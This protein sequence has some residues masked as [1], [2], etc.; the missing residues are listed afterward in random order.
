M[1][2][3]RS[4]AWFW[5]GALALFAQLASGKIVQAIDTFLPSLGKLN[6]GAGQWLATTLHVPIPKEAP[7]W[8]FF[9]LAFAVLWFFIYHLTY[10]NERHH[11]HLAS[12]TLA[13]LALPVISK[14]FIE[15]QFDAHW[16]AAWQRV[17]ATATRVI[18]VLPLHFPPFVHENAATILIV[19]ALAALW[20]LVLHPLIMLT[21]QRDEG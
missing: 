6:D 3:T 1:G 11:G 15:R 16:S 10:R 14:L 8:L 13:L 2:T 20:G 19:S 5:H 17:Q 21:G 12:Y 9:A 7:L 18:D 4:H